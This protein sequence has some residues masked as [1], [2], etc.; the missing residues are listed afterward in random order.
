LELG[1]IDFFG[2]RSEDPVPKAFDDE[3]LAFDLGIGERKQIA[4]FAQLF[5]QPPHPRLQGG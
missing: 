1:G 3:V 5:F 2:T 4:G